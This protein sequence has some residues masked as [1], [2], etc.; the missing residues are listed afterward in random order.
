MNQISAVIVEDE[1]PNLASLIGKLRRS[2]PLVSII[3]QCRTG[4]EAVKLI[5]TEKPQLI[6]LDI[7]LGT[8]SG[9]DVLER[10]QHVS[11]EIIFTTSYDQFAIRAIKANAL[12]YLL[13]PINELELIAA[14]DKARR[15]IIEKSESDKPTR[16]AVPYQ[17][18]IQF[19]GL[20]DIIYCEAFDNFTYIHGPEF[21]PILVS[22]TLKKITEKL[23]LIDFFRIHRKFTVRRDYI[24]SYSREDGGLIILKN[25]HST[26]LPLSRPRKE[27]FLEW[28]SLK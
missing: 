4:E 10:L 14:V 13:K 3:G 9:F 12:D 5:H 8:M 2:C 24:H 6:F 7:K 20:E 16:I 25:Q 22:R 27:E 26:K 1:K 28:L 15:R 11:F 19:I 23:P 21:K 18:G 17:H